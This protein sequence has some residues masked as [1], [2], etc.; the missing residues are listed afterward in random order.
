MQRSP[1]LSSGLA[2]GQPHC[3]VVQGR[4]LKVT[5]VQEAKHSLLRMSMGRKADEN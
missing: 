2:L 3:A 4:R 5:P 1:T